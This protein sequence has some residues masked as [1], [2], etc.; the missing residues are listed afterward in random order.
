MQCKF[1]APGEGN[2]NVLDLDEEKTLSIDGTETLMMIVFC[3]LYN[4]TL[5]VSLGYMKNHVI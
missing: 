2:A 1:Q 5:A 3:E 4:C